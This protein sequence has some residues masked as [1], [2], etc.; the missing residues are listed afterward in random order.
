MM[1][2]LNHDQ[3]Q[4]F[5]SFRLDEAVQSRSARM[6]PSVGRTS[7]STRSA[8]FTFVRLA[9]FSRRLAS[10]RRMERHCITW[11]GHAIVAAAS[12]RRIA[13]QRCH[14]AESSAASTRRRVTWRGRWPRPKHSNDRAVT[15]NVLRC[16]LHISSA[17]FGSVVCACVGRAVPS[18]SSQWLRSRKI[19]VDWESFSSDHRRSQ[20]RALHKSGVSSG[21]GVSPLFANEWMAGG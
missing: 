11:P 16:C 9:R 17:S 8:T 18:S 7:H 21:T 20:R 13:V 2:R 12:S 1:G 10:W 5:Y 3:E 15:A 6:G 4:F 14:C 19:S